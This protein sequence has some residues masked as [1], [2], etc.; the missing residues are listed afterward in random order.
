MSCAPLGYIITGFVWQ[1]LI[2]KLVKLC[3]VTSKP[4]LTSEVSLSSEIFSLFSLLAAHVMESLLHQLDPVLDFV[5]PHLLPIII[6]LPTPVRDFALSQLGPT[7][8]T[9]IFEQLNLTS[10]PECTQLAVSKA[11]GIAIVSLSLVVKVPQLLKLLSSGSARGISFTSYALETIAYFITLAYNVRS[12]NPFSTFGEIA[13]LAAQ[14]VVIGLLVLYFRGK[15]NAASLYA[16]ALAVGGYALFN[17]GLVDNDMMALVQ[18]ATIP[19]GLMSKVPQIWTIVKEKSTGQLSAFA[20][21]IFV[22]VLCFL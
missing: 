14:N 6:S 18:A 8:Y 9:P 16:A 11:V 12:G 17:E 21:W 15:F 10:H 13:I 4:L 5:R 3:C 19:L 20:V 7:C 22:P 2:C 1:T